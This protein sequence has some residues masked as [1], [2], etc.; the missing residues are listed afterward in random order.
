MV[1]INPKIAVEYI[2]GVAVATLTD[3]KVLEEIDIQAL[4]NSIMPLVNRKQGVKLVLDF[5]KVEFLS[6]SSLGLLIRV[7]KKIYESN[8]QLRLCAIADSIMQI[9][10][11]TRL[12]KIFQILP[13]R[14]QALDSLEND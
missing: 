13:D 14:D 12:D 10:K 11:I 3:K 8:G 5:S 2:D 4:E 1:E 7:S 9:F 6:S